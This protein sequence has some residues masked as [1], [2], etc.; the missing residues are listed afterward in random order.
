MA[1]EAYHAS[2]TYFPTTGQVFA[3]EHER[4]PAMNAR[5]LATYK[6]DA[7]KSVKNTIP[8]AA[9]SAA[10]KSVHRTMAAGDGMPLMGAE[11]VANSENLSH[12]QLIRLFPEAQAAPE[13]YFYLEDAFVKRE[14]PMLEFRETFRDVNDAVEY[15]D[16]MEETKI[17]KTSYQEIKYDLKKLVGKVYTP[18]EDIMR[19]II[20][21]Q[22]VDLENLRWNYAWKRNKLAIEQIKKIARKADGTAITG[23]T[24]TALSDGD[25]V[26]NPLTLASTGGVHSANR[27]ASK[28]NEFCHA[29]LKRNDL[30]VTHLLWNTDDYTT[31]T[32]NT[33]TRKGPIELS[34]ERMPSG[35]VV[36][37][38][39]LTGIT[40][41]VDL[42]V[43]KGTIFAINKSNALRIGEG[44]KIMRRYYDEERD[45]EA[46]KM[47]DFV[48]FLSVDD[49]IGDKLGRNFA[50]RMTLK[51]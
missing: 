5:L 27:I 19:T 29:F 42:E 33:W 18:I 45:S 14:I 9:L 37:T 41:I 26:G 39:G 24:A 21:P 2:A 36:E 6:L 23:D 8:N 13:R 7:K 49:Q 40:S 38:P 28:I 31:Y 3:G 22:M 48:Q 44:P 51:D 30:S 4:I 20:N 10:A 46:I 32:E 16:R 25:K 1:N 43:P 12:L 35:G 17:T 15:L 11:G 50:F 47:L 34:P